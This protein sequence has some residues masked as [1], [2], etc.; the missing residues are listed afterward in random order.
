MSANLAYDN[1]PLIKIIETRKD[2][3]FNFLKSKKTP[4]SDSSSE[5]PQKKGFFSRL[6]AGLAK[7][8]AAFS[9]GI[10]TLI[11]GKKTL[12]AE[13]LELIETQLLSADL[14]ID[15]TQKLTQHLTQ[16]LA[17]KELTDSETVL[18]PVSYTHLTLPT[19]YSV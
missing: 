17:R 7:T 4:E 5:Q 2:Y 12:D 10:A 18:N 15:V 9:S 19:I 11:L 3:M 16:Q 14:G 6:T 1:I 8:R 13:L